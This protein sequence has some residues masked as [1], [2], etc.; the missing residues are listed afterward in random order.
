[1]LPLPLLSAPAGAPA[2]VAG[3]FDYGGIPAA[4]VRLDRL[5]ELPEEELGLYSPLILLAAEEPAIALH[6]AHAD[7]ALLANT[8]VIQPIGE[9]ETFNGCIV[10]RVS[11]GG[12]TIYL[13]RAAH[14]LLAA[15]RARLAAHEALRGRRIGALEGG[16]RAA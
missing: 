10:G 7:G 16:G 4:A 5:L 12:D 13:L 2:F 15:E 8:A 3:F 1:V 9:A 14:I 11:E 6:V